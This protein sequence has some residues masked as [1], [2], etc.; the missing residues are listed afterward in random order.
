MPEISKDQI[1]EL[2]VD[3]AAFEGKGIARLEGYVVF[4]SGGVPGDVVK[5]RILRR[6]RDYAEAKVLE[7][8]Q[9]S[10]FRVEPP[11]RY[12][13]ICGG[14]R[15]QHL[16]YTEQLKF[17]RQHVIDA[18]ERTAGIKVAV[19]EAIGGDDIYGYRN[20]LELT[21]SENPFRIYE[22]D[23][24]KVALGFHAPGRYDK[25]ID[26][27]KCHLADEKVNAVIDWFRKGIATDSDLRK[28]S[29]L[30]I[31][32]SKSHSGLLRFLT[33]R[34]SFS[35]DELLVSLVILN[36]DD[37]VDRLAVKLHEDLPFVTTFA[38]I[39]NRSRAQIANGDVWKIHFGN[40][41]ITEKLGGY[42]FRI[43]PLSFFQTNT[44]Q[45][46]KLYSAALSGVG[47][48][49][50]VI[51]DM[52]SGTGSLSIY[53]SKHAEGLYGFE[54]VDSAVTDANANAELN[55]VQNVKFVRTDLLEL[56]KDRN[57]LENFAGLGIPMPE[58]IVL[59][60]PRS[61]LHPKIAS[62]LH[63]LGAQRIVYVSC[64]PMTQARDVKEIASHG[65]QAV[66]SQPVDMF[67]QTYHIENVLV[68]EK[69]P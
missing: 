59:D 51:Y 44:A 50:K 35:S 65:Y 60:P 46:G 2:K 28:K 9:P 52:Y 66:S 31:Y 68:M 64:N 17:K 13:G 22:G 47:R 25:T 42:S 69:A 23:P 57:P 24:V 38:S 3:S 39:I 6:K 56:F 54:V 16:D 8:V 26:I 12:F 21:F 10:S 11:C 36:G 19:A 37:A 5:A 4:V 27:E 58:L 1:I 20:K 30:T 32:D 55:G 41:F 40:G 29:G 62:S 7:V 33:I 15:W 34:R 48:K 49:R 18:L 63:L 61:G 53:M 43:S 67:P 45:A 14:C